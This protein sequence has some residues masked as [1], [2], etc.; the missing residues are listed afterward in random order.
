M[1]VVSMNDWIFTFIRGASVE[2]LA[3]QGLDIK[4]GIGGICD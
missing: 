3:K 1:F 2:P 4:G